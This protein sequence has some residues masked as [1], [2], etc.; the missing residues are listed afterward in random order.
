LIGL[1]AR[2]YGHS[3]GIASTP[4]AVV[5][6]TAS[7]MIEIAAHFGVSYKTVGRAVQR[8]EKMEL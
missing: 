1:L 5:A 8:Y 2:C 6:L 7:T 4:E 3:P